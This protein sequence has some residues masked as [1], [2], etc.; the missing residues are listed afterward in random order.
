[1]RTDLQDMRVFEFL[2]LT[3]CA[4]SKEYFRLVKVEQY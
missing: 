2:I 1:M 4:L 3:E